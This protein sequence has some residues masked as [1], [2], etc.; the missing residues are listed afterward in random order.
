[1]THLAIAAGAYFLLLALIIIFNSNEH[2]KD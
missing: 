2:R 1:M